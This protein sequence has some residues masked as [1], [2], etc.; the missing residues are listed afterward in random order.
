MKLIRHPDIAAHENISRQSRMA[1]SQKRFMDLLTRKQRLAGCGATR[2]EIYG[3]L[4]M[5]EWSVP[6]TESKTPGFGG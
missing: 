6:G 1:E 5:E 2:Q 3:D 4:E